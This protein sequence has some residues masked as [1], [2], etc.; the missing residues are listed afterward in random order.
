MSVK[1]WLSITV[2]SI[3]L[4]QF[5]FRIFRFRIPQFSILVYLIASDCF[6]TQPTPVL[7]GTIIAATVAAI[8]RVN[9]FTVYSLLLRPSLQSQY[10]LYQYMYALGL[11]MNKLQTLAALSAHRTCSFRFGDALCGALQR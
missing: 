2:Y 9:D 1:D 10:R 7:P 8:G 3:F 6:A 11:T 5:C 4:L